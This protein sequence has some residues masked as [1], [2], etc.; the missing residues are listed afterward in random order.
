MGHGRQTLDSLYP[1]ARK[2]QFELKMQMS[3]LDSGRTG[4]K[5]DA[6]LQSRSQREPQYTGAASTNAKPTEKDT[7]TKR[8]QQLRSETHALGS[9]LEQHIYSVNRRAVEARERESLMSRRN[10]GFDSGNGA[11]YAAQESE[12]LQRSSQM[13]SDLTSLSQ[14][15]LGDLGEQR[16]RMKNVRTKL[17]DIANRLG[18]SSSLLR[19][20]ERRDT[21]DFWIVIGGMIFTLV[22]LYLCYS[23]AT[24]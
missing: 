19:V 17:L 2:L 8:L 23:F 4:G 12:S 1:Q 9:T 24:S 5:T 14:S 6:E 21:V 11:M 13:V 16:N 3:Y 15:I 20:I 22:F 10:A 7:W 18:L